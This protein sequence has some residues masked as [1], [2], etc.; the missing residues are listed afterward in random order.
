MVAKCPILTDTEISSLLAR[1]KV[2]PSNWRSK[3][4]KRSK[5][6][7]G[8]TRNEIVI[9]DNKEIFSIKSRQNSNNPLDF[10]IIFVYTNSNNN[11]YI[12]LR[13]N[14]IHPS[15]H[16]NRWEKL[17]GLSNHTFPPDFHIHK[18]T[19]RYQEEELRIEGYAEPTENYSDY[20]TAFDHFMK[21]SGFDDPGDED[22][23][24][25]LFGSTT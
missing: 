4:H 20:H 13:C 17:H 12:I 5:P 18:A 16:T 7:D 21:I 23:N 3:L 10:S 24:L 22:T 19:Q 11:K 1:R 25:S 9:K 6:T 2:L 15:E 14:C 8:H